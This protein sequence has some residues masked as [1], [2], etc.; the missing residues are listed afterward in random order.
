V[1]LGNERLRAYVGNKQVGWLPRVEWTFAEYDIYLGAELRRHRSLHWGTVLSADS[2]VDRLPE[3]YHYYEYDAGKDIFS[4]FA[5][6]TYRFGDGLT[7]SGSVQAVAQKYLFENEKPFFV[8]SVMAQSTGLTP[9]W[10]SHQFQVAYFF[11]NPRAGLG[12]ELSNDL[13][14]FASFGLTSREPRLSDYY[15]A[16][17]FAEPNFVRVPSGA[18][19]FNQPKVRPER[20]LDLEAGLLTKPIALSDDWSLKAGANAFYM[21]FTDELVKTEG[22][23]LFGSAVVGNAAATEHQGIEGSVDL[24]MGEDFK[25]ELNAAVSEHKFITYV[26]GEKDFAGKVPI[27]FP[28]MVMSGVISYKPIEQI[29]LS[30]LGRYVGDTYGDRDNTETY[31]N[32]DYFVMDGV[33]K[34]NFP[35]EPIKNLEIKIQA[36]N[37]LN[38]LYTSYADASSGFFV[39]APL[40]FFGEISF[41]F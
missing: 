17:A 5:A 8:D 34:M 32:P 4:P 1:G 9:G 3:E 7:L 10:R 12:V 2:V 29:T 6:M 22:K 16:E 20:L 18:Y 37:L 11:I 13:S 19:D 26:D 27:G 28:D 38:R 36:N 25:F 41:N 35:L 14:A 21:Y 15:R 23:D 31:R 40:H 24:A 39:A 33:L 30:L